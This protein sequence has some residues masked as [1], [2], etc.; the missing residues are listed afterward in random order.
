MLDS[1]LEL[2]SEGDVSDL[3]LLLSFLEVSSEL[4]VH[5]LI[6]LFQGIDRGV[7]FASK[8]LLLS[9]GTGHEVRLAFSIGRASV[10]SSSLAVSPAGEVPGVKALGESILVARSSVCWGE[11][12]NH[13]A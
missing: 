13:I 4:L 7:E 2:F 12:I 5:L 6:S 11:L 3:L 10:E 9:W 1:I 8:F